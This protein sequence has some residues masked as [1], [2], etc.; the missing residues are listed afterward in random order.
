[1]YYVRIRGK[2]FGP[3]TENQIITLVQQGKLGRMNEIST[4]GQQWVRADQFERF[5]PKPQ[6]KRE[7]KFQTSD[8]GE[9]HR[10][11]PAKSEARSPKPDHVAESSPAAWYYSEDGK[12]G[13]GPYPQ[14]DIEQMIR[15]EK[16]TGQTIL[17]HD[18]L[19]PQTAESVPEF[20]RHFRK[21]LQTVAKRNRN[22]SRFHQA[23]DDA[24]GRHAAF[25]PELLEQLEKAATWSFVLVMM[26]TIGAAMLV[27]SQLF[28]FVLIAQTGSVP[29][30]LGFLLFNLVID[31]VSG[32]MVVAFWRYTLQLKRT[33]REA[34]DAALTLAV[35]RMA[36]LWRT[37]V[38]APIFMSLF[39]L[40]TTLLAL[41]VG[42]NAIKSSFN[43][44]L[45]G[46]L[47]RD[48]PPAASLPILQTP[49]SPPET[50]VDPN[51]VTH[52]VNELLAPFIELN[53]EIKDLSNDLPE[54][55]QLHSPS[56]KTGQESL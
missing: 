10:T 44:L 5:F 1:M 55:K 37:C 48:L 30:T 26:M 36:E 38:L 25:A 52:Q 40:V 41:T 42:F 46:Q 16:I 24:P 17:W 9:E 3:L 8:A 34:D 35:R 31:L 43:E 45:Q 20:A 12:T 54:L 11:P 6:F 47:G 28:Q 14:S 50:P 39:V 56:E 21:P 32:I 13:M 7:P 19:D 53:R 15:H 27:I 29:L 23:S 51:S 4:D 49:G 22:A 33:L 18:R 2:V